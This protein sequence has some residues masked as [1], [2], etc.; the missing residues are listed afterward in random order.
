[1]KCADIEKVTADEL[2]R[3]SALESPRIRIGCMKFPTNQKH[4][5]PRS[6]PLDEV[7]SSR[8]LQQ[9]REVY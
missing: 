9:Q 5:A 7:S 4:C 1:M 2:S 6:A 8:R 3:R